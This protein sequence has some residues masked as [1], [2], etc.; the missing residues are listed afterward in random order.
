MRTRAELQAEADRLHEGLF[1][2][3]LPSANGM[4]ADDDEDMEAAGFRMN[5][6]NGSAAQV[7]SRRFATLTRPSEDADLSRVNIMLIECNATESVSAHLHWGACDRL[8]PACAL[9]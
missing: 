2:P 5:P 7:I 6:T 3:S 9:S 8:C 4:H 1:D